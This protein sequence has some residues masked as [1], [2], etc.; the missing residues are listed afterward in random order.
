MNDSVI[1]NAGSSV[2]R[3]GGVTGR[4]WLPGQ[5]GNAKGRRP[6]S[7]SLTH[8]LR[9]KLTRKDAEEIA[10]KLVGL[11]KAGDLRAVQILFERLDTADIETRLASLESVIEQQ[12]KN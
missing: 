9:R 11:A 3:V 4:G 5:S 8:A 12:K 2:K 7:A 1:S 10:L 6:A